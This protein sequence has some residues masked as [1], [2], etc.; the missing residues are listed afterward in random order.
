MNLIYEGFETE[1]LSDSI[2][3]SSC[4]RLIQEL[5]FKYGLKVI[6]AIEP[7]NSWSKLSFLLADTNGLAVGKVWVDKEEGHDVYNY[8][9]PF[10]RK[11][12]GSD[13]ADRETVHS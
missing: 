9:S 3:N 11:E 8:R 4:K 10:Y 5:N 2:D 1:Q 12:R 6:D 13:S 7:Q